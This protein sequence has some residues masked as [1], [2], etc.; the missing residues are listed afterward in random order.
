MH[1]TST[2]AKLHFPIIIQ[3]HSIPINKKNHRGIS[4]TNSPVITPNQLTK[5]TIPSVPKTITTNYN[6]SQSS[7]TNAQLNCLTSS[8]ICEI[9]EKFFFCGN[10]PASILT[11]EL[12]MRCY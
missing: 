8:Y 5:Q 2:L 12:R 6:R 4:P 11:E 7:D 3:N 1:Q 9:K 10:Y